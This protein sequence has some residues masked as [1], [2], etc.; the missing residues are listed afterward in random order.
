MLALIWSR[1]VSF[2]VIMPTYFR[3]QPTWMLQRFWA[4]S[5]SYSDYLDF[6]THLAMAA[7]SPTTTWQVVQYTL[8]SV[9]SSPSGYVISFSS[10]ILRFATRLQNKFNLD[11]KQ[12]YIFTHFVFTCGS[13]QESTFLFQG[14][15][16]LL[17][18]TFQCR[19]RTCLLATRRIQGKVGCWGTVLAWWAKIDFQCLLVYDVKNIIQFRQNKK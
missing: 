14:R 16:L 11:F 18:E 7:F 2:E 9:S 8:V 6:F 13:L 19:C 1:S 17:Q 5:C 10:S 4:R 3:L 15:Y 12:E